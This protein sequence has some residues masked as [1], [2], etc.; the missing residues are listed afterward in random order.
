MANPISSI[1][2]KINLP[3]PSGLSKFKLK[4]DKHAPDIMVVVGTGLVVASAVYACKKTIDAK[5]ILEKANEDLDKIK[6]GEDVAD[7]D[8]GFT[9][10]DARNERIKVYSHMAFDL[11]KCYG[12]SIVGGITGFG[13]IFGAH[14]IL[15]DRNA[16][17]AA[18]YANLLASYNSYRARVQEVIGEEEEF[19]IHS[20]AQK[21]KIDIQDDNGKVKKQ[22]AI[23]FHDD[24]STHSPYARIFDETCKNWSRSPSANMT[25]IRAV[26][27]YA[28]DKL[29]CEGHLFLNE[30][31][32]ALGFPD[33]PEGAIMGWM[34]DPDDT[35]HGDNYVDFGIFDNAKTSEVVRDFINGYEPC[36]WLDFNVDGV[37]YNLI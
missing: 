26:Q 23:V 14:K 3:M 19:V 1:V 22:D 7:G 31:Y 6:Y 29:R 32:R 21:E 2:K 17:I 9:E 10:K 11:G 28:N 25:T 8:E 18:A 5:D 16:V 33:T 30:V 35:E 34:W 24:G 12:P 4:L 15:K 13:L 36:V 20:G 37:I 27:S